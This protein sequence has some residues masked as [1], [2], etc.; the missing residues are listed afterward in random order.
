MAFFDTIWL[1]PILGENLRFWLTVAVA[2]FLKWLFTDNHNQTL[3]QA[4]AGIVAGA[5][6]AYYGHE[7]VIRTFTTL[8]PD[9]KDIVLIGLVLTGEHFVRGLLIYAPDI[10]GKTLGTANRKEEKNE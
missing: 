10:M 4:M 9:D 8:T 6:A 5:C 2:S 7:W 1:V 3:R